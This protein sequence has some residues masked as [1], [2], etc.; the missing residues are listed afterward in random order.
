MGKRRNLIHSVL[1]TM[2]LTQG[3]EVQLNS[4]AKYGKNTILKRLGWKSNVKFYLFINYPLIKSCF[5]GYLT[6]LA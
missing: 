5:Q 1:L 3:T 6:L 4:A 2:L